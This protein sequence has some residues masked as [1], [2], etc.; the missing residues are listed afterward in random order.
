MMGNIS[1]ET[2]IL[3]VIHEGE[4]LERCVADVVKLWPKLMFMGVLSIS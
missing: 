2:I 3:L 4:G 1:G